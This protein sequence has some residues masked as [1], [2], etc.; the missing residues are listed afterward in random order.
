M[1]IQFYAHSMRFLNFYLLHFTLLLNAKF[2]TVL[3]FM[4][5]YKQIQYVVS[6]GLLTR[7]C[8]CCVRFGFPVLS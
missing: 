3:N 4:Y 8:F 6:L 1:C 7:V 5:D 2:V